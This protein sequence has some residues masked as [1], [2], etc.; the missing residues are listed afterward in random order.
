MAH[1]K[2]QAQPTKSAQVFPTR[3]QEPGQRRP[4]LLAL[5]TLLLAAWVAMLGWMAWRTG[6]LT[7]EATPKAHVVP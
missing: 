3:L 7:K 4:W 6:T 1:R 5:T 2:R